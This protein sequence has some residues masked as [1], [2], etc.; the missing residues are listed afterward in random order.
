MSDT[1][2]YV[3]PLF[4]SGANRFHRDY[5]NFSHAS[6]NIQKLNKNLISLSES[7]PK[8]RAPEKV[9]YQQEIKHFYWTFAYMKLY[10]N[11]QKLHRVNHYTKWNQIVKHLIKNEGIHSNIT[12]GSPLGPAVWQEKTPRT[13][14]QDYRENF[15]ARKYSSR[16]LIYTKAT[17]IS[18]QHQILILCTAFFS[19]L[20]RWLFVFVEHRKVVR[21]YAWCSFLCFVF[22]SSSRR[23]C[24][25]A[26]VG[27]GKR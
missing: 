11:S 7:T 1:S 12:V 3:L 15:H 4:T 22:S 24:S 13:V 14:L 6:F 8:K 26:L 5:N 25:R 20:Q 17:R 21:M 27:F 10:N 18:L 2:E 16:Q 9:L 19:F 23:S